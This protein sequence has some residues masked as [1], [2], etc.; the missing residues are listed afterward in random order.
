M[1][2]PGYKQSPPGLAERRVCDGRHPTKRTHMAETVDGIKV[3]MS[4]KSQRAS[5]F[6]CY[7]LIVVAEIG[8]D[9]PNPVV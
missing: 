6:L 3:A 8:I 2:Q 4:R 9:D 7:G 1:L 5:G